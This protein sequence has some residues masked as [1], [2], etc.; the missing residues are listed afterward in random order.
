MNYKTPI[1]P[2]GAGLGFRRELLPALIKERNLPNSQLELINFFEV[3]PENWLNSKGEI[4]G[5]YKESLRSFTEQFDFI[6]HGL[7]LS[8]GSS[9][10]LDTAL[11]KNIKRFM[12][13]HGISLYTEHLSWCSDSEGHLYDL[14]P[15][16]CTE[17][18]VK[19]VAQRIRQAQ[20]ILGQR[21]GFENAS[22]YFVPPHSDMTDAEFISAVVKE[23]DCLLHLDI[24]NIFV[25][26]QNFNFDPYEYLRSLPLEKVC[27]IHVAGHYVDTDGFIIDT[28]GNAVI[29]A[30]WDLLSTA[31]Q[32]IYTRTGLL[33]HQIPTCLER[34]FN[35]P[36]LDELL[37]EV[38][39]IHT[40]QQI[41]SLKKT[42]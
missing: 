37:A 17:E 5:H 1:I 26:S 24:N 13:T 10:E 28:H 20:D 27:Y 23:A 41:H 35:F 31:Y 42:A 14:L 32:E 29:P 9:A 2:S 22:Y 6:C 15:I 40:Q 38:K 25:N 39:Y 8:I 34:D 21:I 3:S 18:A 36:T 4:G 33:A 11:L 16:P 7:S 19:W 30:V 12:H